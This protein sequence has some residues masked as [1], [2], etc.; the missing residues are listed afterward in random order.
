MLGPAG[1]GFAVCAQVRPKRMAPGD[2]PSA[3]TSP[4]ISAAAS[5]CIAGMACEEVQ[6]MTTGNH[7]GTVSLGAPATWSCSTTW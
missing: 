3:N 4:A 6:E 7:E 5:S 2:Y 1:D